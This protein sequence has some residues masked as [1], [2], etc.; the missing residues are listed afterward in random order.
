[1]S[2]NWPKLLSS[3]HIARAW[4]RRKPL[5]A[6]ASTAIAVALIVGIVLAGNGAFGVTDYGSRLAAI[7]APTE[8]DE[9]Q[10]DQDLNTKQCP[11]DET[12]VS[13]FPVAQRNKFDSEKIGNSDHMTV[14]PRV[15]RMMRSVY[16][17]LASKNAC[18]PSDCPCVLWFCAGG[19]STPPANSCGVQPSGA[20]IQQDPEHA[21]QIPWST[22]RSVAAT[23]SA[24]GVVGAAW[25]FKGVQELPGVG[26]VPYSWVLG[27][28]EGFKDG[29]E[30][31]LYTTA[32]H[33]LVGWPF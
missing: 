8:D 22:V 24:S 9:S 28:G 13:W 6:V 12:C 25:A 32:W 21:L 30:V 17:R 33:H 1:M 5:Q 2:G 27:A 11:V 14:P 29:V 7:N 16:E 4:F 3:Q 18:Q 15:R 23:C 19:T 31:C 26:D 10:L 20:C